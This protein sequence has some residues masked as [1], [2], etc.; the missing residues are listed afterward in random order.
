MTQSANAESVLEYCIHSTFHRWQEEYKDRINDGEG[1]RLDLLIRTDNKII[2]QV[3]ML[4]STARRIVQRGHRV[5]VLQAAAARNYYSTGVLV[6]SF[7]TKK[8]NM[9][10]ADDEDDAQTAADKE[11]ALRKKELMEELDNKTGRG[12]TDPWDLA[13]MMHS[14]ERVADLPD[15]S[16]SLVSRIS[17]ER[18]KIHPDR[19]P[20]LETI[21]SLPLPPPPPPDPAS[22]HAKAYA[23]WRKRTQ[24]KHISNQVQIMAQAK[25]EAIQNLQD[26]QDKQDA[27]DALFEE[28]EAQLKLAEPILGAHA[29]FGTWVER[30]L[31]QYLRAIQK[32]KTEDDSNDGVVVESNKDQD[33]VPVFM[34]CFGPGDSEKV[35]V[36]KVLSPLRVNPRGTIGNMVE[37][38]ELSAHKAS[39]RIMLRQCTR[40]IAKVLVDTPQGARVI[41][42]GKQ[43]V[44]KTAAVAAIVASAR[45]SGFIVLYL[46][47]GDQLHQNGFY[48]VPNLT[49]PGIFDLPVLSQKVCDDLCQSHAK[50]LADFA[51]DRDVLEKH[52]SEDQLEVLLKGVDGDT[53]AIVDLLTFGAAHPSYASH[54]YASAVELLMDQ[55]KTPF[56][57]VMD[58]F[59]CFFKSGRYFHAAYDEDVKKPIPYNN[60][61]LFKPILDAMALSIDEDSPKSEPR[62]MKRGGVVVAMTAS[63]AVPRAVS[64]TLVATAKDVARDETQAIPLVHIEVPRFSALEVEHMLANFEA[65][66]LGRLRLDQG[67][68][69]MNNQEVAFL[70][71]RLMCVHQ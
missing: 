70:R 22:G 35:V 28:I 62:M 68:T 59:N 16:P 55:D 49:K 67:E 30:A 4:S 32:K 5:H 63:H 53:I 52:F 25:V 42:S 3:A 66:G 8:S 27:V 64:E 58:E 18:V 2:K 47:D 48:V 44:G 31:E 21:A 57:L 20:T 61:S 71:V 45:T 54:C 10:L 39:K 65:T 43:G 40:A 24:Y 38:W 1:L 34:D 7:S 46:P 33:A 60:I 56:L 14:G 13:D 19:I 26:W 36:P 23:L 29:S 69:V 37:Q 11:K 17:Q 15:W 6:R 9:Y 51:V 41:V 12:W 50:D